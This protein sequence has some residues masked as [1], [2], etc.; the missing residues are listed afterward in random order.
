[1]K[2]GDLV[3]VKWPNPTSKDPAIGVILE[4]KRWGHSKSEFARVAHTNGH[5]GTYRTDNL[6]TASCK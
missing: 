6:E 5:I 3:K 1:M 4:I 2:V